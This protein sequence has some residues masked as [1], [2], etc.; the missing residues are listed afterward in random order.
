MTP[1]YEDA[2][3][4][5]TI[6][7]ARCED[8]LPSI[9]PATVDL[10]LTD[11]PYGIERGKSLRSREVRDVNHLDGLGWNDKP[12]DWLRIAEPAMKTEAWLGEWSGAAPVEAHRCLESAKRFGFSSYHTFMLV[13]RNPPPGLNPTFT[14]SLEAC[15]LFR[16]GRP[17]FQHPRGTMVPNWYSVTL[18]G[19]RLHPAQKPLGAVRVIVEALVPR[20]GL[21]LDP[22]MGSGPIAQACHELGRRYIGIELVEDYC[23]IAVSRLSQQT[24]DLTGGP[25]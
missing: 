20:D 17:K 13:K 12:S 11:P 1:Y 7:H 23:R 6:Y 22:F 19:P 16:R 15:W 14:S 3:A 4:G 21:V 24:L 9:D 10:L 25:A 5:I 18:G 2:D 8:V